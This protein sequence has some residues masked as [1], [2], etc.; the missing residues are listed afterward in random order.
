LRLAALRL[1]A[2]RLP[3]LRLRGFAASRLRASSPPEGR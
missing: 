3:A 2:L 1:P